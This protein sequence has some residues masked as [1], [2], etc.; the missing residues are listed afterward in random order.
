MKKINYYYL[1]AGFLALLFSITHELNGQRALIPA[2]YA[3]ELDINTVTTFKY[4]W[5][6]ITAENSVFGIAFIIMAFYK[7][8]EKVKFTAWMICAILVIRLLVIITTT[9]AMTGGQLGN[10]VIDIIAIL[11]YTT[12]IL[13]GT[14][15]KTKSK[16]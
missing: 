8:M 16:I 2:L 13:L 3:G 12:I 5:H 1:V 14:R 6:I 15:V 9:L 4:I 7:E 10:L 11:V